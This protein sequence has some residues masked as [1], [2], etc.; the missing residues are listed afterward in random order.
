MAVMSIMGFILWALALNLMFIGMLLALKKVRGSALL[1]SVGMLCFVL[2]FAVGVQAHVDIAHAFGYSGMT[3]PLG[4]L[5]FVR[6]IKREGVK[7]VA[8]AK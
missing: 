1:F 4:A 5:L 8:K 3:L 6:R 2:V 7:D